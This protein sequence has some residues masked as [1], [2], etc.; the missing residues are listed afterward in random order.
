M[1]RP[2][3]F[4]GEGRAGACGGAP[5]RGNS[6]PEPN[7]AVM[8]DREPGGWTP[9]PLEGASRVRI[10]TRR[11][12]AGQLTLPPVFAAVHAWVPARRRVGNCGGAK[13]E[14]EFAEYGKRFIFKWLGEEQK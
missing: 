13:M 1:A 11:R 4:R 6:D 8:P 7:R 9:N 14:L 2:V 5:N 10:R 3:R 12:L